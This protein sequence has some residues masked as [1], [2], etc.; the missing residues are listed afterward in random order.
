MDFNVGVLRDP[1]ETK[2]TNKLDGV[3]LIDNRPSTDKLHHFV[4]KTKQKKNIT[5]YT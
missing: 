4:R 2:I 1:N 3:G 5:N